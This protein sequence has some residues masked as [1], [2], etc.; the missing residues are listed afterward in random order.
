M[1]SLS[2]L[3]YVYFPHL[4]SRSEFCRIL[5]HKTWRGIRNE[6][7][8]QDS[9]YVCALLLQLYLRPRISLLGSVLPFLYY[10]TIGISTKPHQ[11]HQNELKQNL[12]KSAWRLRHY[13]RA[14]TNF[15]TLA[16]FYLYPILFGVY[17]SSIALRLRERTSQHTRFTLEQQWSSNLVALHEVLFGCHAIPSGL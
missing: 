2:L 1:R 16:F 7:R 10:R 6:L 4:E 15:G 5:N 14:S 12:N 9:N 11:E 17:F 8:V 3:N 13:S